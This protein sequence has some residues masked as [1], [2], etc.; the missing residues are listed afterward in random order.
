MT[1][2]HLS[3]FECVLVLFLGFIP[4]VLTFGFRNIIEAS[5]TC[6]AEIYLRLK[7]CIAKGAASRRDCL[8]C[9]SILM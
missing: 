3:A 5:A 4:T 6:R 7:V 2:L 1:G 8:C 9:R